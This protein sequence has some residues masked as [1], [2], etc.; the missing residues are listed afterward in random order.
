MELKKLKELKK[1]TTILITSGNTF[2]EHSDNFM[3]FDN[4]EQRDNFRKSN[5]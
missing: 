1:L 4:F 5:Q 3:N 2:V